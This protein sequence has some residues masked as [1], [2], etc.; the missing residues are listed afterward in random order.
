MNTYLSDIK[1][2]KS[3]KILISFDY[4]RQYKPNGIDFG[5]ADYIFVHTV[6]HHHYR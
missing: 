6:I 4:F 1:F 2:V 5:E 3:Y